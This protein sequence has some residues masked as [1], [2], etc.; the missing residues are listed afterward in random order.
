LQQVYGIAPGTIAPRVWRH[1]YV[2]GLTPE[3]AANKAATQRL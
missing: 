3:A 1:A 2:R